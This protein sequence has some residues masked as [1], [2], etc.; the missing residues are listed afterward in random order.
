M[1]GVSEAGASGPEYPLDRWR[2]EIPL[3]ASY[4]ALNNCSQGPQT[5]RARKA[6]HAY[7]SS[8]NR[9]GMD[10][11]R[12][13][14]EV[15]AARGAFAR[16]IGAAPEEVA[17]TGSVSAATGTVASA[18]DFSGSRR[19]V[20]VSGAEFPGV[21]HAWAARRRHGAEI[22]WVPLHEGRIEPDDYAELVGDD[23]RVVSACHGYY[24]NGFRQDLGAIAEIAHERGAL[25]YVDAYQTVGTT[26][27]DVRAIGVDFLAAGTLKYLL[28]VPGIAF[29]Y[30]RPDLVETL[31][32]TV[33]GW[34]GRSEPF[35][36][37]PRRLDWAEGARR[38]DGGTPPVLGA[39]VAR[40]GISVIEEVGPA[41]IEAWIARLSRRLIEEGRKRGLEPVGPRDPAH[42]TPVTAFSCPR[43]AHEVE[44]QL[45]E[46]G[47]LAS[48]RGDVIRLAPHFYNTEAEIDAALDALAHVVGARSGVP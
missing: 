36:F 14:E 43:D 32:P 2:S 21:A 47:V 29:L 12:W 6:A 16:L 39:Y 18:L 11:D 10:W 17:V 28:G 41:A 30:V 42:K 40:A 19:T 27:I 4:I 25:L 1:S 3:L 9:D 34:F 37:D 20:V 24:E 26:P 8:W 31:E 38:F 13:L 46:R 44:G 15:E 22:R 35:A 33:T 23:T 48:A 5:L 45:R 7:L